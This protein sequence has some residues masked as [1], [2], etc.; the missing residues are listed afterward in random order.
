V[1]ERVGSKSIFTFMGLEREMAKYKAY[2]YSQR[3]MI[4]VSLEEQLVPGTLEFAIQTL[5]EDRMDM[6]VF[7]DRYQNDETGRLAYDPKIL[8]KVVLLGYA[9]GLISSR[10]MEQACRENVTFMALACGQRPDHSTIAAFVSSMPDEIKPL[11]R[12]VLLV[13]EESG[14]LGGTFFALDGCKLPSNASKEWSGKISDLVRKKEKMEKRITEL[15]KRQ[16]EADKKEDEREKGKDIF[17]GL[18]RTKQVERLRRKAER[19]RQFLKG[20]GAKI[21]RT[22]KEVKSNVTDNESANMMTSHGVVQGYNGQAVVDGKFQVIVH[23]EAFGEG[24]DHYHVASMVKGTKENLGAIAHSEDCLEGKVWVADS[25]YSSP[26][27]LEACREEKLDAYI[28]DKKFRTRDPR[29]A[30]Q[31]RWKFPRRKR[32]GLDDFQYREDRD[33]YVC[34]NGKVLH[35]IAKKAIPCGEIRRRYVA[36]REDCLNCDF[37][38]RCLM[39]K[40]VRRRNLRVP[41]G[42]VHRNLLKEM[43]K[44]VDM[45]RG[46]EIYHQRIGIVEPVFANIRAVKGLDRFTLRGKIKV[47][48]QWVLYCMVHNIGKIMSYGFA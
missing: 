17:R 31:E 21:G 6:A 32:L 45:E 4:P 16:V 13:C 33:E 46:R 27:N 35:R 44:K 1:I 47:N 5:V 10:K 2:D 19:I 42:V 14:L 22:G 24:Q 48:I 9:R 36:N 23:G 29:F 8:L 30:T 11:F 34:P 39:G 28:P 15:L 3:V 41:V 40:T 7:E 25:N 18:N 38:A 20:N 37:R 26:A 43:V 12:D